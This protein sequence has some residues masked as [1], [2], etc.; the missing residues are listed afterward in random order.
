MASDLRRC[1]SSAVSDPCIPV[2]LVD[3]RLQ[4]QRR[5]HLVHHFAVLLALVAGLVENLVG[6]MGGQALVPQVNGQA[7]QR[8]QFGGKCLRLG[9]PAG[10]PRRKDA[11]GCPPRCPPRRT[12]GKAAPASAGLPAGWRRCSAAPT[13]A[14]AAP[15]VPARP[16]R[17]RRCGGCRCRGPGSAEVCA[18]STMSSSPLAYGPPPGS[19]A[20]FQFMWCF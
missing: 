17:P 13:S 7:G 1:G 15:S 9:E 2:L 10:S 12:G 8:A 20:V 14:P 5:R 3:K 11:P 18:E 4:N 19:T 16:T 6:L